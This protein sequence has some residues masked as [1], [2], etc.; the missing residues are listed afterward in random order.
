MK[1]GARREVSTALNFN[2]EFRQYSRIQSVPQREHH[3][4]P[5]KINYLMPFKEIIAVYSEKH[6]MQS[7]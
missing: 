6:T 7:Y 5:F 3:T 4:S 2:P 1:R